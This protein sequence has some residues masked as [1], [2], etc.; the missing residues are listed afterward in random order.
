MRRECRNLKPVR[1]Q[2]EASMQRIFAVAVAAYATLAF[3]AST[4]FAEASELRVSMGFG[5]HYLPLYLMQNMKL[6]EKHA[7]A[8]GLGDVKVTYRVIDGGNII[9]D[10]MLS[11]VL[12]V[13]SAGVPGFL[14]LWDKTK[15]LPQ[16]EVLGV[17][18]VGSGSLWLMTRNPKVK[19]LA[20]FTDADRIAVPGIKTSYAAKVLQMAAAQAFGLENYAKLDPLTVGI[21]YPDALAAML[22]GKTEINSHLC[23]PPFSYIEYD[24]PGIHRV[25]NSS[26]VLGK[27]T[28]IMAF[29][30]RRFHEANPKLMAAFTAALD[31]A[32]AFVAGHKSEAARI[33][34]ELATVKTKDAELLRILD[35]P[36]THFTIVPEG[37][38]KYAEFM[39]RTGSLK[40]NP[41]NWKD[42][43]FSDIAGRPGS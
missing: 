7:A 5:I 2:G 39:H 10:A 23:S 6:M 14:T 17:G 41:G 30:T 36:D 31:E 20:D 32:T 35:D 21:P 1:N 18:A 16:N 24:A 22:S 11:G 43:F 19:T 4:A 33:Y 42:L 9:N 3:G 38:M 34:N 8:A 37:A 13:A 28:V 12:D 29:A 26:D 25:V 27:L 15:G 40:N